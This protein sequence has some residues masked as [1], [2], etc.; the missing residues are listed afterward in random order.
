[1]PAP[2]T[3]EQ[4][5]QLLEKSNLLTAE[6]LEGFRVNLLHS[7]ARIGTIPE[8]ARR[9]LEA[10]LLTRFQSEQLVQGKW[11]GFSIGKYK[12]LERLGAGGMGS[13]YLCEHLTMHR[14]VAIKVLPTSKNQDP[15]A[16]GRF[17]RE[18]RAAG[19]LDHP[20]LVRAHDID[21][22]GD[23]HFL[24]M[25]YIDGVNLQQLVHRRGKGLPV[26]R[27]CHYIF[28]TALGLA[29]AHDAGLVH[30]D[31]KPANILL[32]R[33]GIIRILDMGLARFYED[34]QDLLTLKYDDKNVLG[35]ADYVS[36]EQ[37]VNSHGVDI[38]T[39]IYSL[40]STLYYL[41]AGHAP[42]PEGKVSQKLI[43]AQH[44][45]PTPIQ[46]LRPDVPTKLAIIMMKMMAKDRNERYQTMVEVIQALAPYGQEA[47]AL[48]EKEEIPQLSLAARRAG[49]K[50]STSQ[51]IPAP[52]NPSSADLRPS[53]HHNI[54]NSPAPAQKPAV[55]NWGGTPAATAISPRPSDHGQSPVRSQATERTESPAQPFQD[56]STS[57]TNTNHHAHDS[58]TEN[59][60][61]QW[62]IIL[63]TL[64]AGGGI[65]LALQWFFG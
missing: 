64:L 50:S 18:A 25:D 54:P 53:S 47:V 33:Q 60:N 26:E 44:K 13:V 14:K 36:P 61:R 46:K 39:D 24:V 32:D 34:Q 40:G 4:F 8:L 21:Q 22:D 3:I 9:L 42:F 15:A 59:P 19:S 49:P 5:F 56:T 30:R 2:V 43:Y 38:R 10:G 41:L 6:Q 27:A 57:S 55:P 62:I 52:R 37:A 35:T 29:H 7:G 65:G 45:D 63:L 11:R 31:V 17:Y 58:F 48:P 28:Q 12:V 23:L 1:M 16:L 51:S 20:N